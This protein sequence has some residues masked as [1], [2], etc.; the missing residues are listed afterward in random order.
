VE[1]VRTEGL[2]E[3]KWKVEESKEK[4]SASQ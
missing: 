2:G 1:F 4:P 3:L